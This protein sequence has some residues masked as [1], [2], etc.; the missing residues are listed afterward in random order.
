MKNPLIYACITLSLILNTICVYSLFI[1]N[2]KIEI[3]RNGTITNWERIDNLENYTNKY[4]YIKSKKYYG[5]N[6]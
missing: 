5:L 2:D 3:V 4:G 6:R 1:L